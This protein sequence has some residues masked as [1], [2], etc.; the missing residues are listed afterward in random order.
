MFSGIVEAVGLIVAVEPQ[1][2][3]L[4]L[5]VDTDTLPVHDVA[6]GDSVAVYLDGGMSKDGI[7]ST[8]VDATSLVRRGD[9]EPGLVRVLRE[10]A[11]SREQLQEVLGDLLEPEETPDEHTHAGDQDGDS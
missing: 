6:L 9:S 4:R 11:V 10:G 5:V 7:A 1:C 3:G 8:I 2:D